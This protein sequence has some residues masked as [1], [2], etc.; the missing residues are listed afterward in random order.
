MGG[1]EIIRMFMEQNLTDKYMIYLMSDLLGA[2]IPLFSPGFPAAKLHPVSTKRTCDIAEVF[3][4]R[5]E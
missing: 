5:K 2:G 1:G 4:N 3:Y